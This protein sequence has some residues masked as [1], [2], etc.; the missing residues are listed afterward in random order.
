MVSG[1]G[2]GRGA[3]ARSCGEGQGGARAGRPAA[4]QGLPLLLVLLPLRL[5][6]AVGPLLD[7]GAVGHEHGGQLPIDVLL[8][9]AGRSGHCRAGG[10]A[11]HEDRGLGAGTK[12][13]KRDTKTAAGSGAVPAGTGKS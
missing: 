3:V 9:G 10:P 8:G 1:A 12:A 11:G 2:G 4:A 6:G 13:Y 5:A 7:G